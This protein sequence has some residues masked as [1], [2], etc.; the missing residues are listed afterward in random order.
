MSDFYDLAYERDRE[1]VRALCAAARNARLEFREWVQTEQKACLIEAQI[2]ESS[3]LGRLRDEIANTI[4]RLRDINRVDLPAALESLDEAI[5]DVSQGGDED[6]H[7]AYTQLESGFSKET[8][9]NAV[10]VAY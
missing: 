7:K 6:V 1:L 10:I 2:H 4:K 9:N 3:E 5:T 8:L